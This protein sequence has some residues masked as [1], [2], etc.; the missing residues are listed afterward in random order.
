M[1]IIIIMYIY[2]YIYRLVLEGA[3]GGP[4]WVA[5][6]GKARR[7]AC[8]RVRVR[9]DYESLCSRSS[10]PF[11]CSAGLPSSLSSRTPRNEDSPR[12]ETRL[13]IYIYIYSS[14][15]KWCNLGHRFARPR[16][17]HF[18]EQPLLAPFRHQLFGHGAPPLYL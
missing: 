18:C 16:L 12:A 8:G 2:I 4:H 1:I 9:P 6:G 13:Y 17:H 3:A 15:Q 10:E 11:F 14:I 5:G 7:W